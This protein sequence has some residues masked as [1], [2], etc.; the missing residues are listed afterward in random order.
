MK[1]DRGIVLV[2]GADGVHGTGTSNAAVD[3][4]FDYTV[5]ADDD[6][7]VLQIR[8]VENGTATSTWIIS[9]PLKS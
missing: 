3:V 1:V 6:G 7:D 9:R 2:S 4:S 8:F 5:S